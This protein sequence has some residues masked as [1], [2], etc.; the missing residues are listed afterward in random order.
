MVLSTVG[1][2]ARMVDISQHDVGGLHFQLYHHKSDS[3][4]IG[5]KI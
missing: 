4:E 1:A 5:L 3:D 2:V